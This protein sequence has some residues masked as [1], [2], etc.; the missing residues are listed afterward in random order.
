MF[1][2]QMDGKT[3]TNRI[4]VKLWTVWKALFSRRTNG[5]LV[6]LSAPGGV[7]GTAELETQAAELAAHIIPAVEELMVTNNRTGS[8]L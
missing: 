8:L 2:Y 6:I 5:A 1:W 3:L 4:D 7:S